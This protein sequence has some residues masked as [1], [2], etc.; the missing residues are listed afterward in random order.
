LINRLIVRFLRCDPLSLAAKPF[1]YVSHDAN[2]HAWQFLNGRDADVT[3]AAVVGLG[4]IVKHDPSLL[5]L[6]DMPPGWFA[7]RASRAAAWERAPR[8]S[9]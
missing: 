3:D 5:E 1:L 4:E 2:D 8:D 9:A 7:T 6:A